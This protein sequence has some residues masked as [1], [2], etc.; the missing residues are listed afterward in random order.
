MEISELLLLDKKTQADALI[1]IS[2][3]TK[4]TMLQFA[5]QKGYLK[6]VKLLLMKNDTNVDSRTQGDNA[7]ALHLA[8]NN[9]HLDVVKLLIEFG[10]ADATAVDSFGRTPL[11]CACT[12]KMLYENQE[13][14]K[15]KNIFICSNPPRY[16]SSLSW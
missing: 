9:G 13:A 2:T 4:Y 5:S 3:N 15:I 16:C 1:S 7:T 11:H 14:S 12:K 8:A 6:I 10:K